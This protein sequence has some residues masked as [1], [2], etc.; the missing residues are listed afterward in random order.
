MEFTL[1]AAALTAV[2]A[3][4]LV[5][6]LTGASATFDLAVTAAVVGMFTGRIAAMVTSGV[7]PLTNPLD[8]LLVRGGVNTVG[9]AAGALAYLLWTTRRQPGVLARLA[10]GALAGVAG[11]H[12]G[13]LW[14]GSCLGAAGDVAWGW[15]LAGSDVVRHPVELY[16]AAFLAFAALALTRYPGGSSQRTGL[17]VAAMAAAR[18]VTEPLRPGLGAGPIWWYAA[19]VAAGVGW[20]MLG[21]AFRRRPSPLRS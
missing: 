14:T 16:T 21:G 17:A 10:P 8:V 5:L 11:W 6:L 18:L 20:A 9:A 12:A 1:L 15:S 3:M 13:C 2:A 7:N 19:G 4:G